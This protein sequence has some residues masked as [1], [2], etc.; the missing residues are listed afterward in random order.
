HALADL[1]ALHLTPSEIGADILV[2]AAHVHAADTRISRSTE[3]QDAWTREIRLVVPVSDPAL[4][5]VAAPILVRALNFLTGDKWD[6]GFRKRAKGYA[7]LVPAA[8]PDLIPVPFDGVSLFSGGLDS[9]IGAIDSLSAGETPL[10]V[11]HAGE[12]LVSKSQ[13]QCFD[14]LKAAYKSSVFDRLRVW[15]NF[16]SGLVEDVGSEGTT[17]G[18]SFL[19]FSLGVAAGT[20]LGRDFVLKVPENGLIAL[21]VPLD[22]LRLGA[23]STRTTHPFYM[24]RWNDL[25]RALGIGGK[26]ENPYWDRT[27]GEMV[28]ECANPTLLKQLAPLSVSCSS[29]TKGRWTKKPQG[30]CGYCLPCLIRRASLR[31]KDSTIYGVPDLKAATLD[32][33][34]AEG[35]Q[36]R[37]FQIAIARLSKHPGLAK[38]LIHKPGPLYDYPDRHNSLADVYR[39][40]LEEVGCLLNG[41]R[42]EPS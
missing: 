28:A 9:L 6:V 19:F 1:N 35:Q 12:G 14:G 39:R 38:V 31:G 17:R 37:S 26:V 24:A 40:G 4:W 16:D 22:R 29:P 11:S 18:R 36:V 42:A 10:L 34:Q 13:E 21:N 20:A 7:K 8:A 32:T 27:K 25:L 23:L 2:V 5:A 3:S 41:V 30:H 15:M 33:K